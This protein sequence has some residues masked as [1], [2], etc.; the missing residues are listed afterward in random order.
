MK[1][2][3]MPPCGRLATADIRDRLAR[4]GSR[5]CAVDRCFRPTHEL[6]SWCKLHS[7]RN[8]K[9]GA[10]EQ[11][12]IRY[13][14]L[15]PFKEIASRWLSSNAGHPALTLIYD[16][17]DNYLYQATLIPITR[18]P[19]RRDYFAIQRL[20]L[21]RLYR[22]GVRGAE[23]FWLVLSLHLY[24]LARPHSLQPWS[25][26]FWFNLTRLVF[27]LRMMTKAERTGPQAGYRMPSAVLEEVGRTLTSRCHMVVRAIVAAMN[28]AAEEPSQK[29]AA[30][31]AALESAD[32]TSPSTTSTTT[33][34]SIN[35]E[36]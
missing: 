7:Q 24:S 30:M 1:E 18:R 20:E 13:P 8:A 32:F 25:R 4:R 27:R 16:D 14:E 31:Q 17:L 29:L 34:N 35:K 28:K 3:A 33:T 19:K 36:T 23:V 2:P 21:Q 10:P 22:E 6:S 9:N 12:A 11:K 26:P 5:A 15:A